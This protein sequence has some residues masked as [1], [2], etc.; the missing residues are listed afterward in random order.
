MN[1]LIQ[2]QQ[3]RV[4]KLYGNDPTFDTLKQELKSLMLQNAR[5]IVENLKE[6]I[7]FE[8]VCFWSP[9]D[10]G[11]LENFTKGNN[12]VVDNLLSKLNNDLLTLK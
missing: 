1:D 10:G 6:Q 2:K 3:E 11:V 4:D 12:A 8:R 7:E 9:N 5:E